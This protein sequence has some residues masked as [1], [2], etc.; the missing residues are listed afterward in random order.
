MAIEKYGRC[1]C[2]SSWVSQGYK[3]KTHKAID[4][5]FLNDYGA[6]LPVMAW[7]SGVVVATGTDSAGGVYVVLQ[8]DDVDCVW[9]TRYWHFK[10]GSVVVKKGQTVKQGDKLGLRGNTGISSGV[11]LHFELWKCP[12][13][14]KYKSGDYSKYAVNPL[15]YTYLFKGQVMK[16]NTILPSKPVEVEIV[17]PV[18]VA[19]DTTKWQVEVIA[20]SLRVR[21]T[22]SLSGTQHCICPK[23]IFNVIQSQDA[24]G[25]TWYEIETDRWIATKEGSWTIN[26]PIPLT[27]QEKQ[28]LELQKQVA[29][30]NVQ[31]VELQ[32]NI[33]SL[34][35]EID[36]L[37]SENLEL[38][39][40][41]ANI[42]SAGGWN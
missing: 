14:Y 20:N 15:K 1:P 10:K 12:K 32:A 23:G 38:S 4:L 34:K 37:K 19:E 7:K 28:I 6:N 26:K 8:H 11:H 30:S 21:T 17:K 25:Y 13:G 9:I 18:V 24:D 27:E 31:A 42:K 33:E 3:T 2:D 39:T 41:L 16:G 40:R 36:R 5:G 35:I 29:E 22:P